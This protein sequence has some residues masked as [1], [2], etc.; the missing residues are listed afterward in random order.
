MNLDMPVL[1]IYMSTY[2]Q[3]YNASSMLLDNIETYGVYLSESLTS[4]VVDTSQ[5]VNGINLAELNIGEHCNNMVSIMHSY[6]I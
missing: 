4:P 6:M 5:Y 3:R 1:Q 2:T